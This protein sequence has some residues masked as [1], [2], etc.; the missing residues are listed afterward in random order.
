LREGKNREV[1]RVLESL[2]LDVNRLIRISYGP[3]Q[4]GELAEGAVEEVKTRILKDQLGETLAREAG[5]DFEAPVMERDED[6]ALVRRPR[7]EERRPSR[8][9]DEEERKPREKPA[10]RVRKHVSTLREEK[11]ASGGKGPRKRIERQQTEDRRGRAVKVERVVTAGKKEEPATRNGRRFAAERNP[12]SDDAARPARKPRE[13][14]A[15]SLR[16]REERAPRDRTERGGERPFRK[17]REEGERSFR[18]REERAPRGERSFEKRDGGKRDFKP[19]GDRPTGGRPG[20]GRPGG[21]RP[22]GGPG[23]KRPSGPRRER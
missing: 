12:R 21:G 8:D 22:G 11:S 20:G 17:P 16:P 10:P 15:R 18:P 7:Y 19:R 2:G 9:E 13:D 14:A 6:D 1:K 3:F 4:L 5:A 23:G